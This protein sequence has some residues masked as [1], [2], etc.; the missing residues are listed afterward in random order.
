MTG[1]CWRIKTNVCCRKHGLCDRSSRFNVGLRIGALKAGMGATMLVLGGREKSPK[2][3][4]RFNRGIFTHR[5]SIDA[6]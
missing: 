4:A 3:L 2:S 5:Q 6:I 1:S